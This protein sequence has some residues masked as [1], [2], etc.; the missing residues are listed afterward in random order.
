M[1]FFHNK[2]ANNTFQPGFSAKRTWFFRTEQFFLVEELKLL[3][4]TFN[5]NDFTSSFYIENFQPS[6][7]ELFQHLSFDRA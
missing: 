2:S 7:L 5:K 4:E 6:L 3:S 1:F